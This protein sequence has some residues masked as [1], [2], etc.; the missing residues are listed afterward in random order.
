MFTLLNM[1][2]KEVFLQV[3]ASNETYNIEEKTIFVLNH[4][5]FKLSVNRITNNNCIDD[6][7]KEVLQEIQ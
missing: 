5:I 6:S 7:R 1:N 3:T 4:I 2:R